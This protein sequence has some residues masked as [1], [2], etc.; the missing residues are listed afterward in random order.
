M[1]AV[2]VALRR[3]F[4]HALN[5][6]S[7]STSLIAAVPRLRRLLSVVIASTGM[8]EANASASPLARY[9][10]PAPL[11]ASHAPSLRVVRL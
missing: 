11:G 8:L 5:S 9:T 1:S 3:H 4:V 10:A 2:R 7:W 6:F